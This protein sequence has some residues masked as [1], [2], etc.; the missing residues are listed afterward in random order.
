LERPAL[1]SEVQATMNQNASVWEEDSLGVPKYRYFTIGEHQELYGQRA[2]PL[3]ERHW[4]L[5]DAYRASVTEPTR[6]GYL[7][8]AKM[9]DPYFVASVVALAPVLYFDFVGSSTREYLLIGIDVRTV[10]FEGYAGGGFYDKDAWY[11][12]L[13][14]TK[15]GTRRIEVDRKLRFQGSGRAELRFWSDNYMENAGMAPM[16][17]FA[18]ELVFRF[19]SDGKEILV[20]TGIFKIDV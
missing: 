12:I 1:Y 11:D 18:I 3:F 16:G 10:A 14:S 5:W 13:L 6:D 17:C 15:V 20:H 2:E 4:E 8:Y 7:E 19:L 9:H